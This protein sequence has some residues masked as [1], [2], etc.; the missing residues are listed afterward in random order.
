VRPIGA[1]RHPRAAL[2]DE[3]IGVAYD[4]GRARLVDVAEVTSPLL[5]SKVRVPARRREAVPRPRLAERLGRAA[6]A[7][8]TLVSAPAGFGKTTLLSQWLTEV[9]GGGPAVAWVSLDDRDNDPATF[10][11]Y[12]VTALQ[13]AADDGAVGSTALGLLR[14]P[15][16]PTEAALISLLND[17]QELPG[18]VVLV[19][20]DY[21]LVEARDIH[22]GIAFLLEHL[23]ARVRLVLATRADPPLPLARLRAG[24]ELVEVRSTDLRFTREEAAAYLAGPMGLALAPDDVATLVGRTEGWAA[25]LQL[26]GLSLQDREDPG[27]AVAEFAGAD[28][29]VVDYLAE[30]VLA[31][32]TPDVRGFLLQTSVLERLTGPLCDA[33]TGQAGAAARLVAL[34]RA[35]LFLVPLDDQRQWY[36]YHHLFADVLRAHLLEQQP[37]QIAELHRRA[38]AWFRDHGDPAAAIRHALAGGDHDRAADLIELTMPVMRRERREAELARWVREVPDE[39][40]RARPVLGAAFV[41]ALAQV[42]DFATVDKRLSD[43]DSA[44]RPDGGPWPERPPPGLVVVEEDGYRSLPATVEMYRAAVALAAHGDLDATVTHARAALSLAPADDD[45]IRAAAGALG[46]LAS[47]TT[48]DLAGAHAAY[49]ESIAGLTRVGFIADVLGCSITLGDIRRTQGRLGDALRTYRQALDL[50]AAQPGNPLRGTADMHVGI[51]EILVE[52]GEL[53]AAAE[54]LTLVERLGQHNGLPQ[55]PYR[56]RL[57]LA[58]LREAEGDLDAALELLDEA[59]RVYDGDYSPN[60]RPVPAVRARLRVRRHELAHAEDWARERQLSTVDEL[61]YLREYEHVTLVRLL[62]AGRR[63]ADLDGVVDL[64]DRLLAAAEEGGRGGTV[65]EV[66]LLQALAAQARG[67]GSDALGPL[68]RTVTLAEPEGYVRLFADEGPPMAALLRSLGR[69]GHAPY[70][71]RLLAATTT[72]PDRSPSAQPLVEPLS[73]RELDVLRLL[74]TELDGP[75]IARQLAVSL[76]TLRTH[77]KRI[78]AKLGVTSR[79]AAVQRGQA[80]QL[81]RRAR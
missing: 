78:Y 1:N 3:G 12:V 64:L 72:R 2:R 45:L 35:N 51:A 21:H 65:I 50:A 46:G 22:D 63:R 70:V 18:E 61:T 20:D 73:D 5:A 23:P 26:A 75:D 44:L 52:R 79:R 48:G 10:W 6:R 19:L 53:A 39:V 81:L 47:W 11:A 57:V 67:A 37:G 41:G 9:D 68:R 77:T 66:L 76:N 42:S 59:D 28:R 15:R 16:P 43:I 49:T 80:L 54:Q 38:S 55:N 36:R 69:D 27:A 33:V 34:E 13:A 56:S 29:F 71:R 40:V 74:A 25:A 32:Q 24:G 14:S 8:L 62:L 7:R 17:L 60:V 4:S 58:R 30:E 31:R